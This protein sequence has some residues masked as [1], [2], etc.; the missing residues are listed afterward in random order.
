VFNQRGVGYR[1][2]PGAMGVKGEEVHAG[3]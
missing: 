2:A 1:F 3:S